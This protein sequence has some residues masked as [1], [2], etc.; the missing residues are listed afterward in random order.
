MNARASRTADIV[1]SVPDVTS[2]TLSTGGPRGDLLGKLDLGQ[3]RGAERGAPAHRRGDG[4]HHL[5]WACPRIIGP[6][7]QIRSM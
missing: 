2:R 1:A 6:Q 5:G 3:G 4:R 7:E